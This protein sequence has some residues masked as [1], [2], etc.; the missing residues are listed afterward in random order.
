VTIKSLIIHV[1]VDRRGRPTN[2]TGAPALEGEERSQRELPEALKPRSPLDVG[3]YSP[4]GLVE[5][6]IWDPLF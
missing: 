4:Y 5:N 6:E 2:T 3:Q 1:V